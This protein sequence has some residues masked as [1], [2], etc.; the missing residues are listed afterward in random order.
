MQ[1]ESP[2]VYGNCVPIPPSTVS[3]ERSLRN[4]SLTSTLQAKHEEVQASVPLVH[5]KTVLQWEAP[6]RKGLPIGGLVLVADGE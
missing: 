6:F 1:F 3:A 4:S 2:G 5:A